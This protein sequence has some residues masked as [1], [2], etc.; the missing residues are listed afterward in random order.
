MS[1]IKKLFSAILA[2]AI[3][4][5]M[6][7]AANADSGINADEAYQ[8][9]TEFL[10]NLIHNAYLHEDNDLSP[11]IESDEL[12]EYVNGWVT[13][14]SYVSKNMEYYSTTYR[15]IETRYIDDYIWLR[16]ATD[17]VFGYTVSD[18]VSKAT[19]P[20]YFI[21]GK[22]VEGYIIKDWSLSGIDDIYTA[23]SLGEIDDI[24]DPHFWDDADSHSDILA[25]K[26]SYIEMMKSR[27]EGTEGSLNSDEAYELAGKFLTEYYYALDQGAEYDFSK[28]SSNENFVKYAAEKLENSLYSE[29]EAEKI[30]GHTDD[31]DK[32]NYTLT[33]K[34]KSCEI[35]GGCAVVYIASVRKFVFRIC[36]NDDDNI[37]TRGEGVYLIIVQGENGL[38]IVDWYTSHDPYD[39]TVRGDTV[40]TGPNFWN[41]EEKANEVFSAQKKR[42]DSTASDLTA[43]YN[44]IYFATVEAKKE[45]N[46]RSPPPNAEKP[47]NRC[48]C[49]CFHP[50]SGI[51]K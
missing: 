38:E 12:L 13:A 32:L 16:I 39:T 42:R 51:K 37:T 20:A 41:D 18:T 45:L 10:N 15:L 50:K 17:A 47:F 3:S 40:N 8:F 35:N 11:Y 31:Y 1:N 26:D 22:T 21:I 49:V 43:I 28:Y 25:N 27:Y 30:W 29:A 23:Y 24:T 19:F 6:A 14:R 4:L 36:E 9:S 7:I 5:T 33:L 2:A 34:N 48:R 46:R 44:Q